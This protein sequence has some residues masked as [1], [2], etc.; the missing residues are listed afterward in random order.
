[1]EQTSVMLLWKL[2][3]GRFAFLSFFRRAL[4][5]GSIRLFIRRR[6][7]FTLIELLI[8]IAVIA[9]LAGMLL[10]ALNLA[11]EKARAVNCISNL[12]Q[13]GAA[14][15]MYFNDYREYS[16][17]YKTRESGVDHS[18]GVSLLEYLG[19]SGR[20]E[21]FAYA[22]SAGSSWQLPRGKKPKV[23][24][25]PGMSSS[26][27]NK[28][29]SSAHLGYGM[30]DPGATGISMKQIGIPGQHL[31]AADNIAGFSGAEATYEAETS[32]VHIV[33]QGTSW[34]FSSVNTLI[35]GS[36]ARVIGLRHKRMANCLFFAGNVR[37]LKYRQIWGENGD[38][39]NYPFNFNK[40]G[41]VFVPYNKG[42]QIREW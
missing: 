34:N 2:H 15:N 39:K 37:P 38:P 29:N 9:I 36:S 33:I 18:W 5:C 8:V 35:S 11:G 41:S 27:C 26:I 14:F 19:A 17:A 24:M 20:D 13:I 22:L 3:S 4:S 23:L 25:C 1:M 40:E 32:G 6:Y 30:A 7:D 21:A 12:K 16:P 10:P 31:L 42:K 28:P